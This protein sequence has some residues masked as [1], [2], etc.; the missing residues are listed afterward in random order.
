MRP[1]REQLRRFA[2]QRAVKPPEGN[3]RWQR[4]T[5]RRAADT[6]A[7]RLVPFRSGSIPA[8]ASEDRQ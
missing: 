8:G 1:T 5:S 4:G 2:L 3:A 7:W 6:G